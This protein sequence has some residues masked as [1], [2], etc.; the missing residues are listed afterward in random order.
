MFCKNCNKEIDDNAVFCPYCGV[1]QQEEPQ[2]QSFN[3]N[4]TAGFEQNAAQN[5]NQNANQNAYQNTN[6]NPYAQPINQNVFTGN[7]FNPINKPL[8]A[9]PYLVF[10]ILTTVLCFFP[11][12]I[13]AIVY[14]TKINTALAMGDMITAWDAAKKSRLFSILSAVIAAVLVILWVVLMVS[15]FIYG[16]GTY[17]ID[18]SIFY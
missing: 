7:Q 13:P 5:I 6:Q 9:T 14:A 15:A 3:Q 17:P 4:N 16:A 2:A 12:G 11:L 18:E 1:K 8:N 10:A